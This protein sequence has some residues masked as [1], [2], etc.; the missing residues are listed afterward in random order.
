MDTSYVNPARRKNLP[1]LILIRDP[2]PRVPWC[3]YICSKQW[4]AEY[5]WGDTDLENQ[6]TYIFYQFCESC[7]E[8]ELKKSHG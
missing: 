4:E 8:K 2:N 6:H 7:A 3:C 5:A 1:F